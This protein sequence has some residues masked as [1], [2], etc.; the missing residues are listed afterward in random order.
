[1]TTNLKTHTIAAPAFSLDWVTDIN[2]AKEQAA[3]DD[4]FKLGGPLQGG[5]RIMRQCEGRSPHLCK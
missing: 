3:K 1:M 4:S 5:R 2:A